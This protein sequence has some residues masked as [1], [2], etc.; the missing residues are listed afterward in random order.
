MSST[1]LYLAS[2]AAQLLRAMA[3]IRSSK[4][5]L[6]DLQR[7]T[8]IAEQMVGTQHHRQRRMWP[9]C[10]STKHGARRDTGDS[11]TNVGGH[12]GHSERNPI[13]ATALGIM[14]CG[15]RKYFWVENPTPKR[16]GEWNPRSVQ[17]VCG[18]VLNC[19]VLDEQADV[20]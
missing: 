11:A 20:W 2:P 3:C 18:I 15:M 17:P 19:A 6:Y 4:A 5:T 8:D 16:G 9:G 13:A 14:L 7:A 1:A 12:R 10:S